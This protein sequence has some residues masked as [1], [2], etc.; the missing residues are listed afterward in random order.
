[1]LASVGTS[2]RI[3]SPPRSSYS[4]S[5]KKS[6]AATQQGALE[7]GRAVHADTDTLT[8]VACRSNTVSASASGWPRRQRL[9]IRG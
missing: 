4:S 8:S 5:L 9:T 7:A 6:M 3:S 1:M 2:I